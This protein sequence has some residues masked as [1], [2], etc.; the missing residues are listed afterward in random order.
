MTELTPEEKKKIYEEEKVRLEAQEKIQKEKAEKSKQSNWVGIVV[1]LIFIV[2]VM[3]LCGFFNTGEKSKVQI[4]EL[5]SEAE[6]M[7]IESI[8][9]Y[10]EV[11]DA[12]ITQKNN[13]LSL[14]VI[15]RYGTDKE[16]AKEMGDNF[17]R[18]VKSFSKDK[19][20]TKE[21]GNGIYDYIIGVY[22]PNHQEIV[23]G[24]KSS[25]GRFITW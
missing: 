25:I 20:P 5:S 10:S 23:T 11:T 19:E 16:K 7:A 22:Y 17:V 12:A 6:N 13:T 24:A 3:Y 8:K 9:E 2:V 15:V 21:I 14:A 18:M 4:E 1:L